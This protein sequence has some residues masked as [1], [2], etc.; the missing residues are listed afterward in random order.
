MK[1]SKKRRI[2]L[3]LILNKHMTLKQYLAVMLLGTAITWATVALLIFLVNPADG[4]VIT[5]GILLFAMF[6]GLVGIFTIL[7]VIF[8]VFFRHKQSLVVQQVRIS[9]RQGSFLAALI[10]LGL[11]LSHFR[12]FSWWN[13]LLAIFVCALLEYFFLSHESTRTEKVEYLPE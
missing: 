8:R 1:Q 4:G 13:M 11:I 6:L 5:V 12:L 7:G 2:L 10:I 3:L 9:L